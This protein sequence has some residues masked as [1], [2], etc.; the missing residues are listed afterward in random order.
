MLRPGDTLTYID[1]P[2]GAA[3]LESIAELDR[4]RT[5]ERIVTR[6]CY[7]SV[8]D[9]CWV[10]TSKNPTPVGAPRCEPLAHPYKG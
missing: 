4:A 1:L 5:S 2:G 8:F 6:L 9:D 7:C 3:D 10:V